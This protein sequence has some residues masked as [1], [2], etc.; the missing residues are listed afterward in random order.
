MR[1]QHSWPHCHPTEHTPGSA[2]SGSFSSHGQK[3][4]PFSPVWQNGFQQ[5]VELLSMIFMHDMTQLMDHHQLHCLRRTICQKAGKAESIGAAAASI[6]G[7]RCCNADTGRLQLHLR[8]ISCHSRLHH[9]ACPHLQLC[10]L[11]CGGFRAHRYSTAFFQLPFHPRLM[12]SHEGINLTLRHS[13]GRSHPHRTFFCHL[14]RHRT[15][16]GANQFIVYHATRIPHRVR[17]CKCTR[18]SAAA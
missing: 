6:A 12:G 4:F 7:T 2:A 16:S 10:D 9:L 17:N 11:L 14:Q 1:E 15:A 3:R 5:S 8:R 13:Q 18:H